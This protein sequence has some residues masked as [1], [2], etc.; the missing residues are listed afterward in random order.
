MGLNDSTETVR[1]NITDPVY[2]LD[3]GVTYA[4]ADAWFGHVTRNLKL[5]IVY[6][7]TDQKKYPC[8]VWI[9][10]GGWMQ[11]DRG[12]HLAYL[13]DLARRGFAVASVDYRL[14]HEAPFPGALIDIKAAI[15]FLRARAQR[16][17]IDAQKFGVAGESAGGYLTAMIALTSGKELEKGDHLDKSSA[18]QAAC[19]WYMPC[20]LAGMSRASGL[21][22][23]FFAGDIND[24]KYVSSTN[25]ISYI[26]EKAPPFLILHGNEDTTV[27]INQGVMFYEALKK[28]NV[29]ARFI[30]LEGAGHADK[31]FFQR[32]LWDIIANFFMEKLC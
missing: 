13:T 25:P 29:D 9:C 20:D 19:P 31:Q 8:I 27:P 16:Y 22:I 7:Q 2:Y 5:D 24:E 32:P 14:G 26:T 3:E 30:T 21:K 1:F 28:K 11:M 4:Q 6:P 17:S 12:A 15:R 10:G 23:P 18:V